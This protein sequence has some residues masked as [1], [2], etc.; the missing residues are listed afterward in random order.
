M[1]R[2]T[3]PEEQADLILYLVSDAARGLT[4]QAIALTAGAEW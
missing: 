4:G 3:E 2:V 1:K